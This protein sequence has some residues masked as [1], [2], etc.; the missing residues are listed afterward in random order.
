MN[1]AL[2]ILIA[3]V[4]SAALVCVAVFARNAG[5]VTDDTTALSESVL[6]SVYE[7]ESETLTQ[8]TTATTTTA[9]ETESSTGESTTEK[10]GSTTKAETTT[11]PSSS[12]AADTTKKSK[13]AT[14]KK[15]TTTAQKTTEE[16]K[17]NTVTLTIDCTAADGGY[18]LK[19]YHVTYK[20]GDSA[21]DILKRACNENGI[22]V[23]AKSTGYGTYVVGIN[24]LNEKDVGNNSG[25]LY[26]VNGNLPNKACSKYKVKPGDTVK[27]YYTVNFSTGN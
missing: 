13:T 21:Y 26:Y 15:E 12:G 1:R 2:K 25:W 4:L 17:S 23:N 14:T 20:D 3:T 9:P 11:N 22:G 5:V 24:G 27:F 19:N 18:L 7:T 16:Q 10:A 6:S 8:S